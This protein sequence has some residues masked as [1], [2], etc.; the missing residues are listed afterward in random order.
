FIVLFYACTALMFTLSLHDALPL[1]PADDGDARPVGARL[2]AVPVLDDGV[3]ERLAP[4]TRGRPFRD[5]G[6]GPV[7]VKPVRAFF[8][9]PAVIAGLRDDAD[10]FPQVLAHVGH[11]QLPPAAPVKRHPERIAEAPG[12]D[13]RPAPAGGERIVRRDGVRGRFGGRARV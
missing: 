4:G 7:R 3:D 2:L 12:V 5:D 11:E 1:L 9:A 8:D 13:F 6:V 10:L